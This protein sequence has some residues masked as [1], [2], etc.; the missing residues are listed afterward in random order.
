MDIYFECLVKRKNS[1]Q[2]VLHKILIILALVAFSLLIIDLGLKYPIFLLLGFLVIALAI[3][4]VVHYVFGLFKLE[5]EYIV[6]NGDMDVDKII[7]KRKRKRLATINFRNIEIMAPV[8][9]AHKK[10]FNEMTY[11]KKIDASISA[12]EKN[13]YFIIGHSEKHGIV[14]LIFNPDE[15][16]IKTAKTFASRKV[17]TD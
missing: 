4:W 17:F 1:S 7:A 15:R 2:V 3:Y 12:D 5:F 8:N 11:Q 13:T 9:G 16:I 10:E 14:K 6:T